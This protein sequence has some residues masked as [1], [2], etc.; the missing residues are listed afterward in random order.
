MAMKRDHHLFKRKGIYYFQMNGDKK[1]LHT[2]SK[3]EARRLRD[4]YFKEMLLYGQLLSQKS[5]QGDKNDPEFGELATKWFELKKNKLKKSTII[6]YR[7]SLNNIILPRF[8]NIPVSK[9]S[10]LDI[11]TFI[12]DLNVKNKRAKNILVPMRNVFKIALREGYIQQNPVNL[13]DPIQIEK[14]EIDPLSF[15]EVQLII[16]NV[17][18]HYANFFN[19]AFFTGMRF[20]E[21][22]ALKW[23]NVDFR[24]GVIKVREASVRGEEDRPK[25]PGSIRDVKMFPMVIKALKDQKKVTFGKTRWVFVNI[26]GRPLVSPCP[27]RKKVWK[28]ALEKS[29]LKYRTLRQTRHTFITMMLD[30]G[31]H[32]G[33]VA[34]QAGHTSPKMILERYYSYIKN[35]QAEDGQKFLERVYKPNS[36]KSDNST[37]NLPQ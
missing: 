22:A 3:V 10:Y 36:E 23:K 13:L 9:I 24:L 31:E 14:P 17:N 2:S 35:Y 34:R 18:P 16:Q 29:D 26:Y 30:A 32:I 19:V 12:M 4:Q 6:D 37:P 21:L 27:L 33:W 5:E 7:N 25:T 15:D 20:S 8:G 28:K 1:S 11:E